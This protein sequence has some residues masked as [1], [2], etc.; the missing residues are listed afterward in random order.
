MT[1]IATI[2][3]HRRRS[4]R[5]RRRRARRRRLLGRP[6]LLGQLHHAGVV[7]PTASSA[8]V[9][10]K[11]DVPAS[12]TAIVSEQDVQ[13]GLASTAPAPKQQMLPA[14]AISR[15]VVFPGLQPDTGYRIVVKARDQKGQTN[16]RVGTFR[17]RKVQVAVD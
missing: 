17:T 6:R 7:T 11:T 8:T 13:L 14:F 10:I 15:T 5:T 9:A 16:T 2:V 1:R 4:P 12:I 3:S